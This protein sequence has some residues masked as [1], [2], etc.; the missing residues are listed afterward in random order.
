MDAIDV[1]MAT[2]LFA[3]LRD[4]LLPD[5]AKAEEAA[6]LYTREVGDPGRPVIEVFEIEP[7]PPSAFAWRGY[8]HLDLADG[9]LDAA[10]KRAHDL[11]AGLG[12]IHSHPY[13]G[14]ASACFSHSDFAGLADVV[15]HVLW[16]LAGRPYLALVLA[17][18]A[19]DGLAWWQRGGARAVRAVRTENAVHQTTGLSQTALGGLRGP[20]RS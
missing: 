10:I 16:R 2:A 5:R 20:F 9:V 3:Q 12:E 14:R 19:I 17:P 13:P 8:A 4:H 11:R 18:E 1:R 15:P 6:F 7:I